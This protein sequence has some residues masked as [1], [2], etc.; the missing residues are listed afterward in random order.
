MLDKIQGKIAVLI[1]V[2]DITNDTGG[3]IEDSGDPIDLMIAFRKIGLIDAKVI[4][5]DGEAMS[6]RSQVTKCN[7]QVLPQLP[8][9]ARESDITAFV[10]ETPGVR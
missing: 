8:F 4:H 9:V 2:T 3:S 1:R 6:W 7:F 10:V 5:P